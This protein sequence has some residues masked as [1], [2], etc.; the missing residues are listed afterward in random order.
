MQEINIKVTTE[1]CK[2]FE[3]ESHVHV[4]MNRIEL[5]ATIYEILKELSSM[6][7]L[8]YVGASIKLAQDLKH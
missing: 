1:D 7:E 2:E 3:L 4:H 6:D 5:S 8:A